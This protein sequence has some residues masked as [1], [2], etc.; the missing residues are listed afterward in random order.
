METITIVRKKQGFG[1]FNYSNVGIKLMELQ[2]TVKVTKRN[3][4]GKE[5]RNVATNIEGGGG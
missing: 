3:I 5:K 4:L 1:K 2:Q